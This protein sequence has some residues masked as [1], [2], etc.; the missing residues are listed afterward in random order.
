MNI[1]KHIPIFCFHRDEMVFPQD[2]ALYL[3][4]CQ[5]IQGGK[6]NT[7]NTCCVIPN[8]PITIGCY[9]SPDR[10]P[11]NKIIGGEVVLS[12]ITLDTKPIDGLGKGCYLDYNGPHKWEF[13]EDTPLYGYIRKN[14]NKTELWYHIFYPYQFPYSIS[15]CGL[16]IYIGGQHQADIETV[17]VVLDDNNQIESVVYYQHGTPVSVPKSELLFMEGRPLVFVSNISH[18]SYP[19]HKTYYRLGG[20][21]NDYTSRLEEG[22]I[23]KPTKV[24][25]LDKMDEDKFIKWYRGNLGN[26]GVTSFRNRM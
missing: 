12:N 14:Q 11:E 26:D 1:L 3:P 16:P 23:W 15:C 25:D 22:N 8:C 6:I 4:N 13:N 21:A 18:A 7:I 19:K 5:M 24:I 20:F 17:K 2:I 10:V 9:R